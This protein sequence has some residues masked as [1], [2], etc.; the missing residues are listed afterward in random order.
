MNM[1][2][3]SLNSYDIEK[4]DNVSVFDNLLCCVYLVCTVPSLQVT[5]NWKQIPCALAS[6]GDS[7]N[8]RLLRSHI[9]LNHLSVSFKAN[10]G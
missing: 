2:Q 8:P 9:R 6:K 1:Q 10:L 5:N 4:T 7:T 3:L